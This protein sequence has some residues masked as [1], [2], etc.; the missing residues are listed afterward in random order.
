MLEKNTLEYLKKLEKNNNRKWFKD[1]KEDFE[2]AKANMELFV[3]EMAAAM[4]PYDKRLMDMTAK[5]AMFRIYRDVR[6]SKDK[7][8]Y[9][10]YFSAVLARE[11]RKFPGSS[12]YIHVEPGNRS[13]VAAGLYACESGPLGRVRK[14]IVRDSKPLRKYMK[15]AA[16]KKYFK[17]LQGE[18]LKTAPQGYSKNH[19][20]ID[21]LRYK[22]YM[23]ST[24]LTD[25]EMLS[26]AGVKKMV[27][28]M[29]SMQPFNTYLNEAI[30]VQ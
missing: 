8:P 23:V 13:I 9:K 26:K 2:L 17:E 28:I 5:Q 15:S 25:K 18:Q 21:L 11:G 27:T 24:K 7:R 6:F 14:A 10:T 4:I 16:F 12:Y 22:E 29:R 3:E 19:P 20:E 1:H 30:G